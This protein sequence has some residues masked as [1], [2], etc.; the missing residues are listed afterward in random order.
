MSTTCRNQITSEVQRVY[1]K[2]GPNGTTLIPPSSGTTLSQFTSTSSTL[3]TTTTTVTTT[4]TPSGPVTTAVW[5]KPLPGYKQLAGNCFGSSLDDQGCFDCPIEECALRC[6]LLPTCSGFTYVLAT[7][8]CLPK[9]ETC[10][11]PPPA[12]DVKFYVKEGITPTTTPFMPTEPE[13]TPTTTS[14]FER[15]TPLGAF[16]GMLIDLYINHQFVD[17]FLVVLYCTYFH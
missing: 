12:D 9:T 14:F 2:L 13:T 8:Q 15:T 5:F 11:Q 16:S 7:R 3:S 4:T 1:V 10:D 17:K 6:S